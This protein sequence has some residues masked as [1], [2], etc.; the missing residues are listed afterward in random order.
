MIEDSAMLATVCIIIK[1]VK[2]ETVA[3][4]NNLGSY[5]LINV[6]RRVKSALAWNNKI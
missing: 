6:A 4:T 2:N 1:I 5:I 3:T